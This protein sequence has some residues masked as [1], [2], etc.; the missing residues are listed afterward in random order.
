MGSLS[1]CR[2]WLSQEF[3]ADGRVT[4][5]LA[6][7]KSLLGEKAYAFACRTKS[8]YVI[9][10]DKSA[11]ERTQIDDLIHEWA[12][13]LTFHTVTDELHHT[14]AWQRKQGEIAA[15]WERRKG[16]P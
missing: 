2:R 6:P 14:K 5:R 16:N 10:L 3:P 7:R 12:H 8:G 1:S 13:V 15:A 9:Y 11:E 4:V